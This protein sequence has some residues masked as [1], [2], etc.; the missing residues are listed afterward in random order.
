MSSNGE[1]KEHE[2]GLTNVGPIFDLKL[3]MKLGIN[4]LRGDHGSGKSTALNA[5]DRAFGGEAQVGVRDG[6][7]KGAVTWDGATLLNVGPINRKTGEAALELVSTSPI[8]DLVNPGIKDE[9]AANRAEI[10]ALLRLVPVDVTPDAIKVLVAEDEQAFERL[11]DMID[12]LLDQDIVKA[13]DLVRREM[14]KAK[15]EFEDEGLKAQGEIDGA[16][17]EKPAVLS[18]KG[19]AEAR[20]LYEQAI[21]DHDRK[22]GQAEQR[23]KQIE[24]QDE[25]R[26]TLAEEPP[27]I[28]AACNE[29]AKTDS[30]AQRLVREVEE[31]NRQLGVR[32]AE[33]LGAK[34]C[35][36]RAG[37]AYSETLMA[38]EAWERQRAILDAPV[39]GATEADVKSAF[40]AK[41][42][43]QGELELAQAT[44]TYEAAC[45]KRQEAARRRERA[46]ETAARFKKIALGVTGTLGKLLG[47]AGVNDLTVDD[48]R[49]MYVHPN[50]ETEP[51][52]RR[53]F[54][55]KTDRA[56][57]LWTSGMDPERPTVATLPPHFWLQLLP[58][59]RAIAHERAK[60]KGMYV[61]TEEPA[62]GELRVEHYE[63]L[64]AMALRRERRL[65]LEGAQPKATKRKAVTK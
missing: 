29:A 64:G 31:L 30:T 12:D 38:A 18:E 19:V 58:E 27:D 43:A 13:A 9:E 32:E 60:V 35:A 48:D 44:E 39:T 25:V 6:A 54:A 4:V 2:L 59:Y 24:R 26:A 15:R 45:Q 3:V 42:N 34:E 55:Q 52:S 33:A 61:L 50:G 53:S 22:S 37:L 62:E 23:A 49:L 7:K 8:A 51:F 36:R 17:A 14:H 11:Q 46:L 41:L 47:Q 10:Q 28:E 21:A 65:K 56:F 63:T 16:P 1:N 20:I 57:D 40:A 5:T